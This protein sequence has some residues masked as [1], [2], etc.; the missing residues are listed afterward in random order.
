MI[1]GKFKK[2]LINPIENGMIFEIIKDFNSIPFESFLKIF[3]NHAK[4][5]EEL[6]KS[7][8]VLY[9]LKEYRKVTILNSKLI[10]RF[11]KLIQ[12]LNTALN[13]KY[14]STK[15][16]MLLKELELSKI[17][18]NSRTISAKTDLLNK[19]ND[20]LSKNKQKLRFRE[21]DFYNLRNQRDQIIN[22]INN[23]NLEIQNL[24]KKKKEAFSHINRITREMTV[25][26]Q[27]NN[28]SEVKT[29]VG[30]E[31][32]LKKSEQIKLLQ[33]RAKDAQYEITKLQ[34]KINDSQL[35]LSEI[36]PN[37]E[38]LKNDYETLFNTIQNDEK[39]LKSIQEEL[40]EY[41]MEN[42]LVSLQ[43]LEYDDLNSLKQSQDIE[44]E[45]QDI[46]SKLG[47]ILESNKFLNES[48]PKNLSNLFKEL[49]EIDNTLILNKNSYIIPYDNTETTEHIENYRK[50]ESLINNFAEI[51]NKFLIK[52]DLESRFQIIVAE[53]YSKFFIK[54]EFIR[55]NKDSFIFED[56]TTPE[57]IF[58]IITFYITFKIVLDSNQIIYSNLLAPNKFNKQG[59]IF[60][61]IRKILPVFEKDDSLKNYNLIFIIS[62]LEL[63]NPI[64][65]LEM[66]IIE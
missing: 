23:F 47:T 64:K 52:I 31:K 66:I 40:K 44:E 48:N 13:Y 29:F 9:F 56:L 43:D 16:K 62:N 26:T 32:D 38:S 33:K 59:S 61:T 17:K 41:I 12:S 10:T 24:N 28:L 65:N 37:Y 19:L 58:F 51:L 18:D 1:M 15:Q 39:R 4:Q 14:L 42:E 49:T 7:L 50:T 6:K 21:E 25:T 63:K 53:E 46:E 3:E 27:K 34:S 60:R 22:K 45:I 36:T 20:S 8:K 57:K 2:E 30:E 35:K 54:P 11:T 55:L 5:Y